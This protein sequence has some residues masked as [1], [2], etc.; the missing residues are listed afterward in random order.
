VLVLLAL[1]SQVGFGNAQSLRCDMHGMG[2]MTH[3]GAAHDMAAGDVAAGDMAAG[4]LT[5]GDMVAGG[6]THHHPATHQGDSSKD[7]HRC[8]C[9]CIGDCSAGVVPPTAPS[10]T[11]VRVALVVA[12]PRRP[13]DIE[14][15]RPTSPEPDRLLPFANGPP[16]TALS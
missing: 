11:T 13:L 12:T 1:L 3:G 4:H 7:D 8:D 10:A 9:S 15:T 5:A 16:A 14:P 6:M 2:A